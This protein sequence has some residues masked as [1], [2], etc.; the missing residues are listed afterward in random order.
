MYACVCVNCNIIQ[1]WKCRQ[2]KIIMQTLVFVGGVSA[3]A[4]KGQKIM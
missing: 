4:C 2:L 3:G 1:I